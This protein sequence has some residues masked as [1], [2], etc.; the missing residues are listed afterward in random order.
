MTKNMDLHSAVAVEFV[1]VVFDGPP[2]HESGRF[3]EVEN[4]R[5]ESVG[6]GEW[7]DRGNGYWALRLPVYT[8]KHDVPHIHG[9]GEM[10]G[11][12]ADECAYCG[13]DLRNPIHWPDV[14]ALH[15]ETMK[16]LRTWV[17]GKPA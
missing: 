3:I 13:K 5:G 15:D 7:I 1:D 2:S 16:K 17:E 12:H 8:G 4:L 10:V 6:R 14:M 11:K 9:S